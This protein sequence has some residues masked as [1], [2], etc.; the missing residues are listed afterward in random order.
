MSFPEALLR[1]IL[2]EKQAQ[3]QKKEN[4]LFSTAHNYHRHRHHHHYHHHHH[5]LTLCTSTCLGDTAVTNE[6][7]VLSNSA[8]LM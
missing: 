2:F 4:V 7:S 8:S 6:Y 3:P 1:G 5:L